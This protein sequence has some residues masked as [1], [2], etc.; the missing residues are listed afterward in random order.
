M[1]SDPA[2]RLGERTYRVY[3]ELISFVEVNGFV[4]SYAELGERVGCAPST[5]MRHLQ[6]LERA[7]LVERRRGRTRSIVIK[8]AS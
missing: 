6:K 2:S 7:D 1:S 4:P 8:V 5:I 3:Y